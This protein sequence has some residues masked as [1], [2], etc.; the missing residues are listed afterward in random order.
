MSTTVFLP[1]YL[2]GNI[3]TNSIQP[4]SACLPFFEAI[5]HFF[6]SLGPGNPAGKAIAGLLASVVP[7]LCFSTR[8]TN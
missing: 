5:C 7:L 1:N 2:S 3:K 4:V 8:S 6:C